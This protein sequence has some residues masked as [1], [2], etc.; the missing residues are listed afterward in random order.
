[1]IISLLK[2]ST[3][4]LDTFPATRRLVMQLLKRWS[5]SVEAQSLARHASMLRRRACPPQKALFQ[6]CTW[7]IRFQQP[8]LVPTPSASALWYGLRDILHFNSATRLIAPAPASL[9]QSNG[10]SPSCNVAMYSQWSSRSGESAAQR[11]PSRSGSERPACAGILCPSNPP[12][13]DSETGVYQYG[14]PAAEYLAPSD[15]SFDF[16]PNFPNPAG[17]RRRPHPRASNIKT[18]LMFLAIIYTYYI[19]R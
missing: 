10:C 9:S 2:I 4:R 15:L 3:P 11:C 13:Y 7:L 1:M 19:R 16:Y 8:K 6:I 17:R 18:V 14:D 5:S 12:T